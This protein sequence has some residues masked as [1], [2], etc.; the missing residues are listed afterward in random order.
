VLVA[1]E[2]LSPRLVRRKRCA[3]EA[4]RRA[5]D[6]VPSGALA[7]VRRAAERLTAAGASWMTTD[8]LV[9]AASATERFERD[10]LKAAVWQQ[11]HSERGTLTSLR[12]GVFRLRRDGDRR[13]LGRTPAATYV[14]D[15]L[16]ALADRG[17]TPVSRRDVEQYLADAGLRYSARA[18]SGGLLVLLRNGQAERHRGRYRLMD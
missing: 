8:E 3:D 17:A 12:A 2:T 14:R 10:T 13:R 5:P 7:A 16:R 1:A 18:V 15:A 6:T 11:A 9:V 4:E